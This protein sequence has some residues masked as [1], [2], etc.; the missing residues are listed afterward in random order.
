M[1]ALS[2]TC[3]VQFLGLAEALELTPLLAPEGDPEKY[4]RAGFAGTL[5]LPTKRRTSTCARASRFSPCAQ[6]SRRTDR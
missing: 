2:A 5:A 1:E 6:R 4:E 3:E